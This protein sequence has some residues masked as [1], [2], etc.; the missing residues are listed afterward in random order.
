LGMVGL[1]DEKIIETDA[2]IVRAIVTYCKANFGWDNK[3]SEKLQQSYEMLRNHLTL[4]T[5]YAFYAISFTVKNVSSVAI[6]SAEVTFND[7]IKTTNAAGIAVFYVRAGNNYAYTVTADGYIADDDDDNL[8]DVSA[9]D[10]VA[11][12]L[13]EV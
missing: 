8:I 13:T 6:R 3:D 4:S 5:D 12:T 2:L 11:I 1:V 10:D 7:E 9:S